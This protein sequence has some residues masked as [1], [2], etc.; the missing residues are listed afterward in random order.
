[1]LQASKKA[2][3]YTA[4]KAKAVGPSPVA[5]RLC[6][7]VCLFV[8][9]F[10]CSLSVCLFACLVLLFLELVAR[11]VASFACLEET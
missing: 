9:L 3:K 8:R 5:A 6:G 4:I 11:L 10:V 2:S 1:M 7:S